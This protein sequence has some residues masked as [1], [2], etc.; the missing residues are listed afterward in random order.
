VHGLFRSKTCI[1][2]E[3]DGIYIFEP[4]KIASSSVTRAAESIIP[5]HYNAIDILFNS[6][7]HTLPTLNAFPASI[8]SGEELDLVAK[9]SS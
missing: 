5:T 7:T 6:D 3:T 8:H 2:R 9:R 1:A 4:L